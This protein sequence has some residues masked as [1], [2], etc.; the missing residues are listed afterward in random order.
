MKWRRLPELFLYL[1][2]LCWF[3]VL[4]G[5]GVGSD[6][7]HFLLLTKLVLTA[8]TLAVGTATFVC[9]IRHDR[10]PQQLTSCCDELL[11]GL[12]KGAFFIFYMTSGLALIPLLFWN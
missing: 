7:V 6:S 9:V 10:E 11:L 1:L 5:F 8:L 4:A 2:A 3:G 12:G